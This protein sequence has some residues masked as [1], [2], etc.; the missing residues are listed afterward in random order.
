MAKRH[1]IITLVAVTL[2][3]CSIYHPQAV[4]I[5]L[6][7]HAGDTRIDVAGSVSNSDMALNGTYTY[8]LTNCLAGQAHFNISDHMFCGQVAGGAY[9]TIGNHGVLEG[10]LGYNA[11]FVNGESDIED[12]SSISSK[13]KYDGNFAVPFGQINIGWKWPHVDLGLGIKVGSY[14]P[15]INYNEYKYDQQG[16]EQL[17]FNENYT[18]KNLLIEPQFIFR[19]GS[20]HFKWCFKAQFS[21][22]GSVNSWNIGSTNLTYDTFSI[23]SGLN[24]SFGGRNNAKPVWDNEYYKD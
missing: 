6:I 19:V 1:L 20:E 9:K 7:D 11:G 5:P 8:G 17:T 24:I 3:S 22:I 18:E 4:D 21:K 12:N 14:I 16:S 2:S 10:Y 13:Y 23:S 15:D